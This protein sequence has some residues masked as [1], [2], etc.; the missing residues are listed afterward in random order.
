M[1]FQIEGKIVC[2]VGV[3]QGIILAIVVSLGELVR[4]QYKPKDYLITLDDAG[5]LA[6]LEATPGLQSAPGLLVFR[7]NAELF[8][9]NASRF[10]DDIHFLIEAAPDPVRWLILEAGSLTDIDYSAGLTLEGLL[11]FTDAR[12]ITGA[13]ARPDVSLIETLETYGLT[14]RITKEHIFGKLS[15]AYA[16]FLADAPGSGPQ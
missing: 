16:A 14:D 13:L 11:D 9:A 3:E 2:A 7:Y 8:Y 12:G 4:R 6:Y 15:D 5:K 10:V 1:Q